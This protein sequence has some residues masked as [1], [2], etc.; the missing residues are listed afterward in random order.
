MRDIG[1][2]TTKKRLVNIEDVEDMLKIV[3]E[4]Y[5]QATEYG[6]QGAKHWEVNGVVVG[7]AWIHRTKNSWWI[8]IKELEEDKL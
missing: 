7:E 2:L 4:K 8:R 6:S 1:L 3:K 5:P